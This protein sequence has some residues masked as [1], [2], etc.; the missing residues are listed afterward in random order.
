MIPKDT[1]AEI[2]RLCHAE[3][4]PVGTIANHLHLHHSVVRRV[5]HQDAVPGGA[6]TMRSSLA[7]PYRPF[8]RDMLDKFPRLCASRLFQM[9]KER[10]YPGKESQF[11]AIVSHMRPKPKAEAFLRLLTLPG[12]QA[13]VDWGHFGKVTIGKAE[14]RLY[15]F[16]MTLSWSRAI[17]LRFYLADNTANFL[18]GHNDAFT[19]FGGVPRDLLYD[20]LKSAVIE[21]VKDAI[22]FND[23]LLAFAGHHRFAPK[24]CNVAR[25]NEKGRVERSIRYIRDN[26]FAARTWTDIDDLNAQALAWCQGPAS[27][28]SWPEDRTITVREVTARERERLLPLPEHPFPVDERLDVRIGKT[29]YARF[30][31]NDY[32]VPHA[33]VRRTLTVAATTDTVRIL[34][35]NTVVATHA[36]TYDKAAQIEDPSHIQ[37]LIDQKR[38]AKQHRGLD[39]LHH[40]LPHAQALFE[41]VALRG[42]GLG[43]L[44]S[45]LLKLLDQYGADTLDRSIAEVM[46]AGTPHLAAVRQIL[47]RQRREAGL[48]PPLAVTLP[49]D[50]RVR[51]LVVH[52]HPLHRYDALSNSEETAS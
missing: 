21:R 31:L 6:P 36:R 33:F 37:A 45:G 42:G 17:F 39:R 9:V 26:F 1:E 19:A 3:H 10:G 8:M 35:G 15:A 41:I 22:R 7:D 34:D 46:Q 24:P 18:R 38:S 13:Q 12:E 44:T 2:L 29:P 28:R 14:R 50:P 5:L 51:N 49:D 11:R 32:S 48:P 4:W 47:D 25:G 20:N 43:G 16:V 30:D 52:A 23:T 27:D 40:A